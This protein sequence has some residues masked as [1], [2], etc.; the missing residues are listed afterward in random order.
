MRVLKT[1]GS[2]SSSMIWS[3][4]EVNFINEEDHSHDL[5]KMNRD[6]TTSRRTSQFLRIMKTKLIVEENDEIMVNG[7]HKIDEFSPLSRR[8]PQKP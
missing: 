6:T 1:H 4:S 8:P 2:S 5:F 3:P 7:E